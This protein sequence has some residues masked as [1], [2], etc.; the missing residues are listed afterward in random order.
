V[1]GILERIEAAAQQGAAAVE[2][3][4][5]AITFPLV[6]G[7][8]VTFLY[9]GEGQ[10]VTLRHW[11][12]GLPAH[13]P[14]L[15]LPGTALFVLQ[16]DLPP[17]SRMEYK[18][19]V[20][21]H[22][23]CA[24]IRDPLNEQAARDPFGANSVVYGQGY[25]PPDWS[26]EDPDARCGSLEEQVIPSLAFGD[27]R[28][29][30]VYLPARFRKTRRYPL[31]VVHDG[32][33]YAAFA[34]LQVVLDNLIHRLELPPLVAA[35]IQSPDRMREYSA[36]DRHAQFV[37]QELV[38]HLEQH[39][40]IVRQPGA[41][42][43]CGAS[44]GAV[45][46]LH[47]AWR[48]PGFFGKLLLQS[49]SFLF[50]DI[51]EHDAG[52]AFDPIVEWVGEFRR[53]PGKPADQVYLSCGVYEGLIYYS[54]ALVPLLEETGMQIRYR[55]VNDGHNWENWRD[56][57]REGLSFLYPGPLWLVYE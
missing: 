22:G 43:L 12:H 50:T 3:L 13:L 35:L 36:D 42:A 25:Q 23:R 32:M 21:Q 40:P 11:I 1:S 48:H 9:H 55:E 51:G 54:R 6:E 31:L 5:R 29:V 41:R 7:R 39:Y 19:G 44:F 20:E 14:F 47:C 46:S 52:P 15:R 53:Q 28:V 4:L 10:E 37:T 26:I 49:G 16:I 2:Q 18:I 57:L 17:G 56:R 34:N 30:H 33:D 8:T 45:A 24:L 38:G 27:D